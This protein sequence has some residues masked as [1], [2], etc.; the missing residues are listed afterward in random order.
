MAIRDGETAVVADD[1]TAVEVLESLGLTRAEAIDQV[2]V[3]Y[4]PMRAAAAEI[5]SDWNA[6]D[7][8]AKDAAVSEMLTQL[9][10]KLGI[11]GTADDTASA[12]SDDEAR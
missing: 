10:R 7:D 3:S 6:L 9:A 1:A 5:P 2:R 4:G 8:D 12:G 11:V